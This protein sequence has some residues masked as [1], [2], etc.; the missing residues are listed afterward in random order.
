MK[1]T[2]LLLVLLVIFASCNEQSI[3]NKETV[4]NYYNARANANFKELG[5]FVSDSVTI[6]AGDFVM[7]YDSAGFYEEFKWDSV[8][9]PS[10]KV[11][12]LKEENNKVIATIA[13]NSIKHEFLKNSAMTCEYKISF[14]SGKIAKIEELDCKD[15]DWASWQQ[16]RDSLVNW[17]NKEHPELN[18]F[19]NDM[20]M[21]GAQ[22]Y[23]KAIE[24][25]KADKKILD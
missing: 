4:E 23:L 13:I 25:Y 9:K 3:S 2:L 8:F 12:G 7:P 14:S 1:N 18:G 24:L 6:V 10:Y 5:K 17:I 16:E 21:M 15:A 19:I 22:N 11:L 20:T